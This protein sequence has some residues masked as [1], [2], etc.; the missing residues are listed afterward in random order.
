MAYLVLRPSKL[1]RTHAKIE[2][3]NA[4]YKRPTSTFKSLILGDSTVA[5]GIKPSQIPD[6]ISLAL[7]G[8]TMLTVKEE[9]QRYLKSKDKPIC[10]IFSTASINEYYESYFWKTFIASQFYSPKEISKIYHN[11]VKRNIFPSSSYS[12]TI[13]NFKAAY[14][15]NF[16][17]SAMKK[18]HLNSQLGLS[19]RETD[20]FQYQTRQMNKHKGYINNPPARGELITER[21]TY[22]FSPYEKNES[23]NQYLEE[24][25]IMAR[26]HKIKAFYL[27]MPI[28]FRNDPKVIDFHQKHMANISTVIGKYPEVTHVRFPPMQEA[29][30]F[31]D[32][33][34]LNS[35]GAEFASLSLAKFLKGKCD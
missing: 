26:N 9:L 19:K 22:L 11:S 17:Y 2:F 5:F 29:G 7:P 20:F 30:Y 21:N 25:L 18:Y 14:F 27:E 24:I 35:N 3:I 15:K 6:S 34:H 28:L 16:Y 13:Y 31:Y 32:I 10:L 12:E 1:E 33:S 8:A 23:D 4:F